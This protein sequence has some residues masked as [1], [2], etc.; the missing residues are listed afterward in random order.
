M[1]KMGKVAFGNLSRLVKFQPETI[2]LWAQVL[3]AVPNSTF[4]FKNVKMAGKNV[5]RLEAAFERGG[6]S[7]DRLIFLP[8]SDQADHLKAY[9]DIDI[10]LDSFPEQ[11]GISSLEASWMGVPVISYEFSKYRCHV[12]LWLSSLL[13]LPD[14]VATEKQQ[15]VDIA[16]KLAGRPDMLVGL[17]KGLRTKLIKSAICDGT[18]FMRGV[19]RA[20]SEMWRRYCAG[21]PPIGFSVPKE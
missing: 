6:V 12:G 3:E 19:E 18:V 20:F 14:L 15:F 4:T 21:L 7:K 9:N 10:V 1:L 11:G 8:W 2:A 5:S 16:R 13:G 17:R